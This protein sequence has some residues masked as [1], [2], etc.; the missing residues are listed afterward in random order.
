MIRVAN[1]GQAL[2]P[3]C[4]A[5]VPDRKQ[6]NSNAIETQQ[7]ALTK[8]HED[9]VG[10]P[11]QSVIEVVAL[12]RGEPSR[13]ARVRGVSWDVHVVLTMRMP[14]LTVWMTTVRGSPRVPETVQHV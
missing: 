9:L 7:V 4:V 14:K 3:N 12:S 13:H 6:G 1:G 2:T 5:L 11:L 10:N 8:L